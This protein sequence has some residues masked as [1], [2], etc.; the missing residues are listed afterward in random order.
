MQQPE[1]NALSQPVLNELY[2]IRAGM[3]YI[4]SE[5]DKVSKRFTEAF[6]SLDKTAWDINTVTGRLG[7]APKNI[8]ERSHVETDE[9]YLYL[10]R[11]RYS[12]SDIQT[13]ERKKQFAE[14]AYKRSK[15]PYAISRFMSKLCPVLLVIGILGFFLGYL[16]IFI[17]FLSFLSDTARLV[18]TFGGLGLGILNGILCYCFYKLRDYFNTSGYYRTISDC[19][20]AIFSIKNYMKNVR[21][22]EKALFSYA[23]DV[24]E[25]CRSFYTEMTRRYHCADP[26]DWKYTDILIFY[27]ETGRTDNMK[28][29]LLH[30]DREVQTQRITESV[31]KSAVYI[32]NTIKNYANEIIKRLDIMIRTMSDIKNIAQKQ[33]LNQTVQ[34]AL[35]SKMASLSEKLASDVDYMVYHS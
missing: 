12:E 15:T 13:L 4:S 20:D 9:E 18:I 35:M 33:L 27:F 25:E 19:N 7:Y 26:R 3:S 29:A 23:V 22:Y 10:Y 30:L 28:E 6:K 14:R 21:S 17:S 1:Q 34:T 5:K 31:E 8:S 2:A 32:C 16:S 24:Y 11:N